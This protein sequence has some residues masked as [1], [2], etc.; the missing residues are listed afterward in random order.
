MFNLLQIS[1]KSCS[2]VKNNIRFNRYRSAVGCLFTLHLSLSAKVDFCEIFG[3][4]PYSWPYSVFLSI[5]VKWHI[6]NTLLVRQRHL[7]ILFELPLC[8]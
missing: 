8:E 6:S 2:Y 1:N 5:L 3:K 7:P 4:K